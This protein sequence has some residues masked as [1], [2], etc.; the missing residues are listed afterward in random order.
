[1]CI[2]DRPNGVLTHPDNSSKS[3]TVRDR[4]LEIQ[5]SVKQWGISDRE[6]IVH[7][8][9]KQT[10]G[11]IVCA[12]NEDIFKLL[13]TFFK[14][15]T[16]YKE[17]VCIVEGKLRTQSGNIEVP[18]SRSRHNRIKRE[19]SSE[20]RISSSNFE[21]LLEGDTYSKLKIELLTGR[22]HQIRSQMEFLGNPIVNDVLY[23]AKKVLEFNEN[24]ICLHSKKIR[25]EIKDENYEFEVN[26]PSFFNAFLNV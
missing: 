5:P 26:E 24:Q 11:L 12:L 14:E 1:M 6:G 8:L 2:R 7:R 23:G 15:R 13:Q 10:S 19:V 25:F 17:Y 16:I 20:G 4:L 18:L 9:D 3:F 22:N 21:V